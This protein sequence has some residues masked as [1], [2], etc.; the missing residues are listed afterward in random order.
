MS[1]SLIINSSDS[2][3][4]SSPELS[5]EERAKEV[6]NWLVNNIT[7]LLGSSNEFV[8]EAAREQ[9]SHFNMDF[10]SLSNEEKGLH[11]ELFNIDMQRVRNSINRTSDFLM[12]YQL[13]DY[14][15]QG[16]SFL[17]NTAIE[18]TRSVLKTLSDD[19]DQIPSYKK[20]L[21]ALEST[22]RYLEEK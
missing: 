1:N 20:L 14:D 19:N 8:E 11:T 22:K 13:Q 21:A 3:I 4:M 15:D 7:P 12:G 6:L 16:P 5:E 17:V 10:D 9:L 2:D 18:A